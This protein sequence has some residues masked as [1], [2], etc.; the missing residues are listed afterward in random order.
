[1]TGRMEVRCSC[2]G[3]IEHGCSCILQLVVAAWQLAGV[4]CLRASLRRTIGRTRLLLQRPRA[5]RR[6]FNCMR[7]SRLC[8]R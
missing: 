8:S 2:V 7:C 4:G 5:R 6:F 1:M 3:Q